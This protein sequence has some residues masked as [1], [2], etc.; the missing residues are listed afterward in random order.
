MLSGDKD[1]APA[2]RAV[3]AIRA[4]GDDEAL[5]I[6]VGVL[7]ADNPRRSRRVV[8]GLVAMGARAKPALPA[9]ERAIVKWKGPKGSRS[10]VR[11]AQAAYETIQEAK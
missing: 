4:L 5:R 7:E 11:L 8:E 6:F 2:Y 9:M 3:D 10:F 1:T